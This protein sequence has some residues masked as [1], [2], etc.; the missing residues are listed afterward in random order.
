MTA[1]TVPAPAPPQMLV[2]NVVQIVNEGATTF[3]MEYGP[4]VHLH[5]EPGQGMFVNEEVA[6]YFLGAWWMDNSNPRNR[7]RANEYQ[8]LRT[9]YGAY[10]DDKIW[11]ANRPHLVAYAPDSQRITTVID[12]P[13][14]VQGGTATQLGKEMS[15]ESQMKVLQDTLIQMQAQIAAQA[16]Q[17]ADQGQQ[18]VESDT[19]TPP[20][21]PGATGQPTVPMAGMQV[22]M[23]PPTIT[24]PP[25]PTTSE[26]DAAL[27]VFGTRI[28]PTVEVVKTD[29]AEAEVEEDAP[30]AIPHGAAPTG[31]RVSA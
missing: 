14:G 27:G 22:P 17:N 10:E 12:D 30:L 28:T 13:E 6:W 19:T 7:E 5:L 16:V 1:N 31:G 18:L 23:S 24:A 2:S 3:H 8:R 29:P 15:L 4:K 9:L 26:E 20:A 25:E 21:I 11:E